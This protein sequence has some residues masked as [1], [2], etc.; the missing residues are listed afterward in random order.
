MK[1]LD[2]KGLARVYRHAA[3]QSCTVINP[4]YTAARLIENDSTMAN[5]VASVIAL[6]MS[7]NTLAVGAC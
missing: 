7:C 2:V 4:T 5:S 1:Q 3:M 6:N